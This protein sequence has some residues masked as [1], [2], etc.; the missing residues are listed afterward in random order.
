MCGYYLLRQQARRLMPSYC[1]LQWRE[2]G[3]EAQTPSI[4]H[5]SMRIY[6][7]NICT[8]K[9]MQIQCCVQ[10]HKISKLHKFPH[11]WFKHLYCCRGCIR[12]SCYPSCFCMF[13]SRF[14]CPVK[15]QCC[16][17]ILRLRILT[18]F[19]FC[20]KFPSMAFLLV[21]TITQLHRKRKKNL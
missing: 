6:N 21:P 1:L 16:L 3:G 19:I 9:H 14:N 4:P 2:R 5:T 13:Q 7:K 20:F 17:T 11:I 10:K 18:C 15:S 12:P 8:H